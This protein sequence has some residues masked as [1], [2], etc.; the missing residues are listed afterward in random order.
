MSHSSE[1]HLSWQPGLE[2]AGHSVFTVNPQGA[3][4]VCPQLP[5]SCLFSLGRTAH[6]MVL[7]GVFL[8]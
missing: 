6:E 4:S 5:L 3:M 2:K 8:H 1:V 7:S